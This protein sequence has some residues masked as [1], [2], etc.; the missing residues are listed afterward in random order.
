MQI[1][2]KRITKEQKFNILTDHFKNGTPI[3]ELARLNGIHPVTLYQWKRLMGDKKENSPVDK[4][5]DEIKAELEKLRS[6]NK[7][8]TKALGELT[9]DHQCLKDVNEFL[10]KKYHNH[11]LEQQKNSSKKKG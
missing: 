7:K 1:Y 10:K 2:R 3:S 4:N 6:E 8:L 9:L 11:L 5:L